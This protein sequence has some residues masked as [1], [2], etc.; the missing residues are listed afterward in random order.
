[1]AVNA[2]NRDPEDTQGLRKARGAFFTPP[3]IAS[4]IVDWAVNAA[5]E[6]VLEPSTGDAEFLV[7]VVDRLISLGGEAPQVYGSELHAWSAEE[8]RRRVAAAG[9]V[10]NITV[11]DFFE[12][13]VNP[14]YDAV[15]GN[16]PY[17][18]F[19]DFAG[20]QRTR[21]GSGAARWGGTVWARLGMGRLHGGFGPTP[22]P[23]RALGFCPACRVAH[24]QLRRRSSSLPV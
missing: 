12:R 23:G 8:G 1:M 24:R 15:V 13:P 9:G 16:P 14:V 4:Y 22:A 10:A 17:I 18:R 2:P 21:Q 3:G 7:H 5:T 6:K 11:G 19:Q 20:E